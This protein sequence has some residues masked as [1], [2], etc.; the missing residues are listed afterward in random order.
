FRVLVGFLLV[1]ARQHFDTESISVSIPFRVLVG[2][3]LRTWKRF[4]EAP[5]KA[6][7]RGSLA[8]GRFC[9]I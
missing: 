6:I 3:L 9:G 4:C 7:P 2:F 1:D 8:S 5:R